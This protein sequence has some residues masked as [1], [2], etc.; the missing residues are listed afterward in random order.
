[1][2][3]GS[4]AGMVIPGL[5]GDCR[6]LFSAQLAACM[7]P[8]PTAVPPFSQ[9]FGDTREVCSSPIFLVAVPDNTTGICVYQCPL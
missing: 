2:A 4:Q 3:A 9:A 6:A 1:M 8:A 7:A 5:A